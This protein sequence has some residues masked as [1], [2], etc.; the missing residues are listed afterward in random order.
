[1]HWLRHFHKHTNY[2]RVGAWRLL[3]FDGYVSHLSYKFISYCESGKIIPFYLL[4]HSTHLLQPLNI[5]VFQPFK[6]Y[7]G[8][9]VE[10]AIRAGDLEFSKTTFLAAFQSI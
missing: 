10:D 6:H 9:A 1:M 5:T 7:H 4:P 2:R 8:R 3:P